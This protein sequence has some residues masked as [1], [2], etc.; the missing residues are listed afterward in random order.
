MSAGILAFGQRG[1]GNPAWLFQAIVGNS[2]RAP[3]REPREGVTKSA[4]RMKQPATPYF[5]R[6]LTAGLTGVLLIGTLM[7]G[8]WK[9]SAEQSVDSSIE[10]AVAGHVPIDLAVVAHV[11]LFA[12]ICYLLPR[13]RWWRVRSWHVLAAGLALALLTEGLQFF[14]VDRHPSLAGAAQDLIGTAIGWA[15]GQ[16]ACEPRNPAACSSASEIRN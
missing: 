8:N 10:V 13:A 15:L 9:R 6:L 7:P 11:A 4:G 1:R 14:A 3:D 5:T 16:R 12:A 2:V